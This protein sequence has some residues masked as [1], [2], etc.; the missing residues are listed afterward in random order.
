MKCMRIFLPLLMLVASAISRSIGALYYD[1]TLFLQTNKQD[2]LLDTISS[3]SCK[4]GYI[5]ELK[6]INAICL[7]LI[8]QQKYDVYALQQ[9]KWDNANSGTIMGTS[10]NTSVS[11]SNYLCRKI[12]DVK[13]I[14]N[15]QKSTLEFEFD[16]SGSS[17]YSDIDK[18]NNSSKQAKYDDQKFKRIFFALNYNIGDDVER[19]IYGIYLFSKNKLDNND[20]VNQVSK[21]L[22]E[23]KYALGLK[24]PTIMPKCP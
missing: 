2:I 12:T 9:I 21:G 18:L 17:T 20:V 19:T 6:G 11:V 8:M 14:K 16:K 13:L 24:L 22:D 15:N 1:D 4:D 5:Y 10:K 7:Y 3:L 23:L